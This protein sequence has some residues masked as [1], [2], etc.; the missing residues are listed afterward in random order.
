MTFRG[1]S[2]EKCY[3]KYQEMLYMIRL[4][5]IGFIQLMHGTESLFFAH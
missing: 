4:G 2:D 1:V 3:L 5:S